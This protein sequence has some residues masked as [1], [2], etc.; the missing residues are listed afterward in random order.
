M[1][2]SSPFSG[3]VSIWLSKIEMAWDQKNKRFGKDARDGMFFYQGPYDRMYTGEFG[4]PW[5][6]VTGRTP[7]GG[8]AAGIMPPAIR[9]TLN[10]VSDLV[11]LFGPYLYYKN[12]HRDVSPRAQVVGTTDILGAIGGGYPQYAPILMRLLEMTQQEKG[13]DTAVS[14]L[15]MQYLNGT[16]DKYDLK[17]H[18][19]MATDDCIIKGAGLLWTHKFTPPGSQS[20]IIMNSYGSCD[21][22]L[23]DPDASDLNTAKWCAR[24]WIQPVWEAERKFKLPPGTLKPNIESNNRQGEIRGMGFDGTLLRTQGRTSDMVCYY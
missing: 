16:P 12:P 18:S 10:K 13:E 23:I 3:L 14:D 1:D 7:G 20:P 22:L 21:D 2:S 15:M 6:G 24:R 9:V 8:Q 4:G 17:S 11:Q 5:S 19:R